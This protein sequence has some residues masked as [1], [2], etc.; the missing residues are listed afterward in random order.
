MGRSFTSLHRTPTWCAISALVAVLLAGEMNRQNS[1]SWRFLVPTANDCS[2]VEDSE[3]SS[4]EVI[5]AAPGHRARPRPRHSARPASLLTQLL[6]LQ[7]HP[8]SDS[9]LFHVLDPVGFAT[10]TGRGLPLRC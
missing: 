8:Q 4:D 5:V 2:P 1:L 7:V 6:R 9:T 10:F 3:E